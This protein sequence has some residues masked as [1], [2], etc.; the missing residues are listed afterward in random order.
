MSAAR[1]NR[2]AGIVALVT[3][4]LL[5]AGGI[6][7]QVGSSYAV[8]SFAL[9]H[10]LLSLVLVG[11]YAPQS[12]ES[13]WLGM[14]G[15]VIMLLGN[16][17]FFSSQV[18]G[19]QRLGP[20]PTSSLLTVGALLFALANTRAGVLPSYAG[21]LLFLGLFLNLIGGQLHWPD[22][23]TSGAAPIANG[24]GVGWFGLGLLAWTASRDHQGLDRPAA[25]PG[26]VH[27]AAE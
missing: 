27:S 19:I 10:L 16:T 23:V 24:L 9:A 8:A 22:V 2:G 6:G 14:V 20:L 17:L 25:E 3:A 21:W 18:G 15:F 1:L 11:I 12:R 7:L 13:G 4:L 26:E 5:I